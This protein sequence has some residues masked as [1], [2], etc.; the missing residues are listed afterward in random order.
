MT[1]SGHSMLRLPKGKGLDHAVLRRYLRVGFRRGTWAA[2]GSVDKALYKC[3]LWVAK[4]RG[5]ITNTKLSASIISI[6]MKLAAT[7][8]GR[9]YALGLARARALWRN[10]ASA[11][12]FQWAPE[13]KL[14]FSRTEYI[15]YLGVMELQA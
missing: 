13:A 15:M 9:I 3:A 6:I 4:A 7:I 1:L 12:V 2:L 5:G 11:G 8:G 14:L 10:Y